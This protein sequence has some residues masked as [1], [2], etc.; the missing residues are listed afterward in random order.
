M[1]IK[2]PASK[3]P[4]YYSFKKLAKE[5]YVLFCRVQIN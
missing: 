5:I 4:I 3:I 2:K 1:F